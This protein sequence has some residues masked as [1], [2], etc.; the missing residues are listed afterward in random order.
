MPDLRESFLS[1]F[2]SP[3]NEIQKRYIRSGNPLQ[4]LSLK[5]PFNLL[6]RIPMGKWLVIDR[7]KGKRNEAE[8]P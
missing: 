2:R 3:I 7:K 1:R 4:E 8:H 6:F 5:I